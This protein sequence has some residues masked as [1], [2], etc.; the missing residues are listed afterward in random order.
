MRLLVTTDAHIMKAPDGSYW[1]KNIYRY[2][3]WTRYMNV[4]DIVRIAS[5]VKEVTEIDPKWKRVDG[6]QVEIFEIPFYQ[7]P[8][9]LLKKYGKIR[10]VLREAYDNCDCRQHRNFRHFQHSNFPDWKRHGFP[11]F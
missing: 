5:R 6:D 11:A 7:G 9:Q 1:N 8:V 2:S 3:F 10:K 4:F